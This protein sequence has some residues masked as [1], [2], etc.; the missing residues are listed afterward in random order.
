M[1]LIERSQCMWL[2]GNSDCNFAFKPSEGRSGGLLTIWNS[3]ILSVHRTIIRDH[4]LWLEGEWGEE[5]KK[6]NIVNVYAPCEARRKRVLWA[7]LKE[8]ILTQR[9][10][11]WCLLGDFNAIRDETERKGSSEVIRREEIIDFDD[12]ISETELI[13]LPLHGR[14]FTWSRIGGSAMSRIDRF[15]FSE[16][17]NNEWPNC[18]QWCLDKALSDHCPIM[19]CEDRKNWGPKPFRMLSCWKDTEGYHNFVREQWRDI[20][21]E[22]WGMFVLKEKL[23]MIKER[24]KVWHKNHT[25]NLGGKIKEAKKHLNRLELKEES[26]GLSE[27]EL[28]TKRQKS[29]QI[30]KLSNLNCSIQW[31]K[32]RAR[33]LKEG[34]ANTKYFHGCINKRRRENE[35]LSLEWNGRML[36]EVDEI[37]KAIVDHF[38]NHFSA[39]GVRPVPG[40]MSFKRVNDIEN[41]ELVKEF[42]EAEIRRAVWD[43]ESTKSPGPDGVN[44]GFIKEFWEDIKDDFIRVMAEFHSNGRIVKGANCSF[45]VLIPKK[46][47]PVK[48]TDFRP[49]CLIGCIYKVISKV[50]ANR[51]K[52]VISSVVSETQS[53]FI[54]GRQILDGILIANEIVDEA[55]RKKKEAFMFKV[56]FEKAFDSVD[57]NFLDIVMQKMGFHE[58]WR[59]W[60]TECLKTNSI[61]VLVNGSPSKEFEM[62]RGLRQ[63][64]PLSPFLFLIAAEGFNLL[65]KKA[66]DLGNFSGYKFDGG[67]ECFSHLQYADDTLIIGRKGWG[68]IRIIKAILLLF[69]LMSGLKVNFHKSLLIG[70]NIHQIWIEEAA[71]ILNC[72]V[73]SFPF[74][75]LGLPIGANPRRIATWQPVIDAVRFRLSGW[76]H[77]QLSIGGR[78]VI[79]KSVLS[80]IPVYYLSFFKAPSGV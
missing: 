46:K 65:M 69:E 31:Q 50:L 56:D 9:E 15:L 78:V 19:L 13:D 41:E 39:R 67:D 21:V 6:V 43:C 71:K 40:N 64:D 29:E 38:Q 11:N 10:D 47:S 27:E 3:S 74:K 59:S 12:F 48:V 79:L 55:K 57:W 26:A 51:L 23:K 58:K 44:F 18:K 16:S 75:Y 34:D 28:F 66:V 25:Q 70:I 36:R 2:W 72:K 35:I 62:G 20:K 42:S 37:K 52:K 80:A 1:E 45:I 5:K 4:V 49:I 22:G 14:R 63:G 53:A 8:M 61:S 60:I 76:K 32:S 24:L 7:D 68:N 77:S 17:W 54:S 30:F 33:W 73:G